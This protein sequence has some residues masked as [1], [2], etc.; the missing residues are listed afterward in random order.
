MASPVAVMTDHE[1][2][3]HKRWQINTSLPVLGAD[4][5]SLVGDV[6]NLSEGGMM[7]IGRQPLAAGD[8][9]TLW[10][11]LPNTTIDLAPAQLP[12]EVDV[13][14][15]GYDENDNMY[16]AGLRFSAPQPQ[17]VETIIASLGNGAIET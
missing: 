3:Q 14:W 2:R 9:M 12:A 4:R 15:S 7:M 10:L 8:H 5:R 16:S 11:A 17:L 6:V 13:V 1:R